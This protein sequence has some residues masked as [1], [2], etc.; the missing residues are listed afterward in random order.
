[1][2][3]YLEQCVL[4][5]R[6]DLAGPMRVTPIPTGKFNDSF[7]VDAGEERLVLR[8]AP[9]RDSVFCFYEREMMRQEPGLHA[10]VRERTLVPVPEIYAFDATLDII[11][12]DFLLMERMP[13]QPL[14][15][16]PGVDTEAIYRETGRC[17]AQVH[18]LTRDA[19]G[20]LGEHQPMAPQPSWLEAFAV[21]WR[22]LVMDI[23]GLECYSSHEAGRM[24]H[25]LDRHLEIFDRPVPA[26]LLHMDIW[27]QNLLV[28][29]GRLSAILDWDRAL[30]GD[31]EI[32]FAVLDYCGVSTPAFWE[33]YGKPRDTSPAARL[34]QRFYLLYELQKYIVIRH[35]RNKNP[36]AAQ[37]YKEEVMALASEIP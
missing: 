21:M 25:L 13:G 34:R 37:Q 14:S 19:Y 4:R 31:P 15:H 28:N 12:R 36:A 23:A 35:G 11:E 1:M 32:E 2:M 33:G 22:M 6:P 27:A 7:F 16:C 9:P 18:A 29:E 8:V 3:H 5:H 24:L 26:S 17:L 20:Y 30:W 10:L